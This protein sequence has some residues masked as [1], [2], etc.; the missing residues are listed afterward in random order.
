MHSDGDIW[1]SRLAS[2]PTL[3][4]LEESIGSLWRERGLK[5]YSSASDS[6]RYQTDEPTMKTP[7]RDLKPP[8]CAKVMAEPRPARCA[9][10]KNRNAHPDIASSE[11]FACYL[12][13]VDS[14]DP[15]LITRPVA[16]QQRAAGN[17]VRILCSVPLK[18]GL[19][20]AR[21]LASKV[22]ENL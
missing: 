10:A 21:S 5:R 3:L 16:P 17:G 9:A 2:G 6:F 14:C 19:S 11:V 13:R 18:H 22:L 8:G 1:R 12:L 15:D 4:F 7:M 20:P